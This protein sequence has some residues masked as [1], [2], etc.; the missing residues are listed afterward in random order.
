MQDPIS[1]II[2]WYPPG[3]KI[4]QNE[5]A[6]ETVKREVREETGFELQLLNEDYVITEYESE[7]CN[8][9]Y[10]CINYTFVG[11]IRIPDFDPACETNKRIYELETQWVDLKYLK[12]FLGFNKELLES[13]LKILAQYK[14][15]FVF[16]Y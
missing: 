10:W 2:Y 12:F 11:T 13:T 7:W 16:K 6:V 14:L 5:T 3:G 9:I 8:D 15:E 1:K 4:E